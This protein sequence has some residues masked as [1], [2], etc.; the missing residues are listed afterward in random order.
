MKPPSTAATIVSH[1][2]RLCCT[3]VQF[4]SVRKAF[5]S[6]LREKDLQIQYLMISWP[7]RIKIGA[8]IILKNSK[9]CITWFH[10]KFFK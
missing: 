6:R 3:S 1:L 7:K 9:I 4:G 8:K 2:K 5:L 10:R